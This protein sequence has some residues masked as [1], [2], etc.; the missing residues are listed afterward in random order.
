[1]PEHITN[2]TQTLARRFVAPTLT[3]KLLKPKLE[4]KSHNT[5]RL[6][7]ETGTFTKNSFL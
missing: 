7:Y 5:L 4:Q 2:L 6:R 1:M 3:K